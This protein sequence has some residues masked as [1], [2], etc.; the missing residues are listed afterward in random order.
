MAIRDLEETTDFYMDR[1]GL[2]LAARFLAAL[3]KSGS[4]IATNPHLGSTRRYRVKGLEGL[5]WL[6]LKSPFQKHLIFYRLDS[7]AID[8]VRVLH[9]SR[10]IEEILGDDS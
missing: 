6:A 10:D 7:G 8:I 9:A 1:Q 2:D 4:L 3:S 5:R